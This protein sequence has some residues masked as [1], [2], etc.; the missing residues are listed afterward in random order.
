MEA[1]LCTSKSFHA[2]QLDELMPH[3]E[4]FLLF[5]VALLRVD[6]WANLALDTVCKDQGAC[7]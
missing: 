1:P 6:S 4:G 5:V 7:Q 2:L 3:L